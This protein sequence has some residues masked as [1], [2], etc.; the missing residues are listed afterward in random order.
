MRWDD[1]SLKNNVACSIQN[2]DLTS[3]FLWMRAKSP[4]NQKDNVADSNV[5]FAAFF[6]SVI[7]LYTSVFFLF[8]KHFE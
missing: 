5:V 4:G 6:F 2:T 7:L 3:P 8:I 1:T